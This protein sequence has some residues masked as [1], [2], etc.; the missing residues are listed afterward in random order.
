MSDSAP[1]GYDII[2]DIHG[3]ATK[4]EEL[5]A[6]LGYQSDG[7]AGYRHPRRQA[8]FVGDLMD[9]GDEQLRVLRLVKS[10]VDAGSAQ[11][12]MGNHEFNAVAYDTEWPHGSGKFLRA[13][14]DPENPWSEKNT[15]QHR[16]FLD[17]VKGDDRRYYLEWFKTMPLWL[18]LGGLR[19]VHA[20]W[21]EDSIALV[22]QQCGSNT[23]FTELEHL[24]SATSEEDALY[25]AV[26]TL[27]KGPEISLVEHGQPEYHDKDGIPRDNARVRWW[28]NDARTLRDI[29]EMGGNFTTACG[30]PY[31]HLPQLELATDVQSFIYTG[32]VP[33]IYGHYW[34]QGRPE[35]RHDWTD[36][37]ACVDFSAVKGGT[38]AAYRWSGEEQIRPE[39]YVPWGGL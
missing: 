11:I 30:E 5:L 14:D 26:E 33:V 6:A 28:I 27:L 12:V 37:T 29:A 17:Q 3:C 24:V 8:I 1:E 34:R 22:E 35:Y 20:C 23:P 19:V 21:H 9:R 16:A 13:H 7:G 2:G 10:M 36:Y 38:L 18:D 39:H 4:L 31:P 32:Q 15:K 25:R